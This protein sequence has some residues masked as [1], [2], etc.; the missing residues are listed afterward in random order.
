MSR[1]RR[2]M[3]DLDQDIRNH[4]A[5]ETQEN[6]ERGMS[7]DE[8]RSS[9]LRKFGNVTRVKEE[10]WGVWSSLWI[11]RFLRDVCFAI[12]ALRKNPGFAIVAVL[13]LALGIGANTAIFSVVQ[14]VVLAPLPYPQPNRLVMVLESRP[15]LKQLG[16]SYPDFQD[17]QR[18]A[19]SFEQMAALT[20][21]SYDL[22]GPGTSEHLDGMEVSSGFFATLGVKPVLG[23]EFSPAEDRPNEAQT[24]VISDRLWKE[25]FASN[26]AALGRTI[27]LDGADFTIT[28]ILP[29]KFRLWTDVDVYTSLGQGEPLLYHDRTIHSIACIARLKPDVSLGQAQGELDAVQANLDRLYPAADR[30]LGTNIEPLKQSM[31][32]DAGGTLMLLLGA[33]GIVL[34]IACTNVANLLLARSAARTREFAIRSALGASRARMVL[35]LLTESVLLAITGGLLGLIVAML[36]IRL[37]L[38]KFPE[39]LPR[40]ENIHL[41]IPVLLF[42]F[43]ISLVV[44]ILFGLAPAL[45]GS[46]VDVQVSLKAGERGS[47]R[48]HPRAQS[49]LVI[50]QMAL[51]LVLLVG[52]GLLLRTVLQLWNVNPGFD[53]QHVITFKVGLSPSLTRTASSTRT[54]YRQ[55]LDRIREIPGVQAADFTNIVPLSEHDNGG[56]FWVGAQQSTSMQDAPH[57][58]YFET[59]PEYLQVMQIPL[60]RGRFFTPADNSDSEPVV[61]IDSVL[62]HTYFPH[63]DPVGQLIT[64]AHWRTARVI[65]VVGHVRHW[66]LGDVGTYNPS[67]IYI[68]FYQLSDEWVPAFAR[69][70]SVAVRTLLDVATIMPAIKNV[71]YG[72]GKDQP[73]Y[74]VQ[75]M[76]QIA[77]DSMASQR[78]PMILL[79]A[80]A[81]LALVLASVGVYG[82]L[83]YSVS[84]RIQEIGIRMALGA[85]R[86]DVLRMIIGQGLRLAVAGLLIGAG[87]ALLLARL[88]SSFSRLLYGVRAND[89][90]TFM[91]VSFVLIG[92]S[93]FACYLPAR[94]ASRV[95]PMAALKY[96]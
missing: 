88:L 64:V 10:T 42:A 60:L 46:S 58:L 24:V 66:G 67:Q 7:P 82:V 92:V 31:V 23:H 94:R 73:V 84:Q 83:S 30:S 34:L 2:M 33:V 6:I 75:T 91:V 80:F 27:I 65:G 50:V 90:V 40:T 14:G 29:P 89:P 15:S 63:K 35:Q 45:N 44:G 26:P 52:S 25:R 38:A 17:W 9:A 57:A 13:T 36:G 51:T 72:T 56:P 32:G 59:G 86:S 79:G 62:A 4:I 54:A 55:L 69:D 85:E 1:R 41:D 8:A 68:S 47:T 11:E 96:E 5:I 53:R 20:W 87:V 19:R 39:I 22:T 95:D 78:L 49:I 81:I 70:L 61:V 12:R 37:V 18:G 3:E 16:I 48:A 71:V 21:R 43:G 93:V 76:Q 77:S 28:G 74:D